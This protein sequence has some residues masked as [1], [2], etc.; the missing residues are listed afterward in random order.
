MSVRPV[1]LFFIIFIFIRHHIEAQETSP[2]SQYGLGDIRGVGFTAQSSMGRVTSA[3]NDPLHIN[4]SNPASYS[5]LKLTTLEGGAVF[6]SKRFATQN[7]SAKAGSGFVDFAALAF[8]I[9]KR[10]NVNEERKEKEVNVAGISIGLIPY[11]SVKYNFE[12]SDTTSDA[13]PYKRAYTGSGSIYQ[14]YVGAGMKFP[15]KND[16]AKHTFAIGFNAVYLFGRNRYV[17]FVDFVN[18]ST[19]LGTRKNSVLRTSDVGWNTGIQYTIRLPEKWSLTIGADAYLPMGVNTKYS[20]V[21]DR[22]IVT[23]SG[24]FVQDTTYQPQEAN[25][26]RNFPAEYG[27]GL[28]LKK[29]N[30]WLLSADVHY[31]TWSKFSDVLNPGISFSNALRINAGTEITPSFKGKSNFFKRTHYRIGGWFETAYLTLNS[32]GISQYGI[33]FGL[34]LPVK[35]SF[36][37]VNLGMEIGQR[38][39]VDNNLTKETFIRTYL[40][41]T[42][43][44]KWF[45]KRKYD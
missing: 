45:I 7:A 8:P 40:G 44:D 24:V 43:N 9:V 32:Q 27:G 37:L 17:E 22:F 21:W 33:T 16:T 42:L 15:L 18:N 1:F 28:M 34:G 38:G 11:S 25:I 31:V 39:T 12:L 4:F 20:T 6:S 41:F 30:N 35:G 14:L 2:Y 3:F 26:K 23:T 36:S 10:Y 13:V 5:T 29:A 19:Y